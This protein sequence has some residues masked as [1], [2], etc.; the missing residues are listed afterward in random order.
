MK[1]DF[2]LMFKIEKQNALY[3]WVLVLI[4]E[5]SEDSKLSDREKFET[6]REIVMDATECEEDISYEL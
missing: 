3:N 5:V 6:I 2:K 1:R 4:R